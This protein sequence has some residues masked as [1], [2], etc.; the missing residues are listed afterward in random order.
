MINESITYIKYYLYRSTKY[1]S[2]L[3]SQK[4]GIAQKKFLI[5]QFNDDIRR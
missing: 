2:T 1:K 5:Q 3:I 4:E